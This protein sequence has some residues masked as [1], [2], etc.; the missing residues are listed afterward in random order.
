MLVDQL[1]KSNLIYRR[2]NLAERMRRRVA[3]A[4]AQHWINLI[5]QYHPS[6]DSVLDLG[7]WIGMDAERLSDR[8][9]VVG[10]DIQPHLIDYARSHRPGL[11]F[12]VGDITSVRLG[13]A[14]DVVLCVGNSLSYVHDAHDLDAAFATF[15]AHARRGSL[16][17]VHTL[18]APIATASQRR[19]SK[20]SARGCAPP[21]PTATNGAR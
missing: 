5:E 14:F 3:D 1:E 18:L 6:A 15:T 11:E 4:H 7:C 20:W 13:R 2:P 12:R 19:R 17:I 9:T 8:Y 21:T 10:V 16:L